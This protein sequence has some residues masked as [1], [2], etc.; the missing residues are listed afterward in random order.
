MRAEKHN[1]CHWQNS[2]KCFFIK[3][4]V[5]MMMGFPGKLK[6]GLLAWGNES[7]NTRE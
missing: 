6:I 7:M 2:N 1:M 3:K 5:H 4:K